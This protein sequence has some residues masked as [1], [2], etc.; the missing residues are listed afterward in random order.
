MIYRFFL[1][2]S[3]LLISLSVAKA[4]SSEFFDYIEKYKKTAIK[5]MERAGIPASIKL[6]QALLESNA[7]RSTLA[8]KANNHFG[9]KCGSNWKGK[10]F[11]REDD[12]YDEFGNIKKSCFRSYRKAVDSYIAHS[13]FLRDPKKAHR[14]G[15]LFRIQTNDYKRWARG[16]KKAGYATAGNY[17][18]KLINIIETYSLHQYDKMGNNAFPDRPE[19]DA[20]AGL[21]LR[22]INGAKVVFAKNKITVQEISLKTGVSVNALNR[23]NENLPAVG[24]S[25]ADDYRIFVQPKRNRFRGKKKW[26][27]VREGETM[28]DISQEYGIRLKKLYRRNRIPEGAQPQPDERIK[29]KGCKVKDGERPRLSSEPVPEKV[30]VLI[31]TGDDDFMDDDI[32]PETPNL[33][34]T[35]PTTNP[36]PPTTDPGTPTTPPS[37]TPN[38]DAYYTVLKGDTLYSISRRNGLTVDQLM[39]MNS[40]TSTILSIGQVLKVK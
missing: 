15:F 14:Y 27:Y 7:G 31:D 39:R 35:P 34:S 32:T 1:V 25:L 5:E 20:I 37:P 30:P 19:D 40:L 24:D 10:T 38:T 26:H 21:D 36:N 29:L 28:F 11:H 23:Y 3:I 13:E 2:I 9:M 12:D 22:K 33:P 4:Q 8:R 16:L 6:A 17:D 18:N